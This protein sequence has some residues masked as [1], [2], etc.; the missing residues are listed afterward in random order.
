M[1]IS[2]LRIAELVLLWVILLENLQAV[3]GYPAGKQIKLAILPHF[4]VSQH[5][6]LLPP[7]HFRK[8]L[9]LHKCEDCKPEGLWGGKRPDGTSGMTGLCYSLLHIV[10]F[11]LTEFS[12]LSK[13]QRSKY[14]Y[15]YL[16]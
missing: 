12:V 2:A 10:N 5:W 8:H 3:P 13:V 15:S 6:F 14:S 4:S 16:K 9:S 7:L 1:R 11:T